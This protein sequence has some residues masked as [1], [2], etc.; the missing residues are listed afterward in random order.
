MRWDDFRRSSNVEDERGS[1]G[2]GFNMP[3]GAGGLGIGTILILGLI[4]WAL[5]IDPSVLI[6]GAQILQGGGGSPTQQSGAPP[7]TSPQDKET[8]DF[9]S[10]VLGD[11][12]DR[13]TEIFRASGRTYHPPKLVLFSGAIQGG[14]GQ[15]RSAMGPFYCPR[16]QQVYLDTS[17]F[18]DMQR[19]F[20]ACSD[21]K[22]CRFSE[23]YVIAH[24]VGHHVQD[25]LGI[26]PRVTQAQ[27]SA[28]SQADVNALQ[29]RVELQADC[30]AGVWANHAQRK[31]SFLDAG[32]VDQALQT[33]SAIGDDR[34]QRET[35]G[36]VV[37]DAF[38]HGTSA[39]RKRWFLNGFNSGDVNACNTLKADSL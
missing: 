37:P 3:G 34:L 36:Y 28:S 39:Q 11:T 31:H 21:D 38:T 15:A 20:G 22:A 8:M 6:N 25:E 18:R 4:G 5:G 27:Q 23:A 10:A 30:L 17:F 14:C 26:L 24:E 2:G 33:A 12:E 19:K 32:D 29:V 16:D 13:W 9:V 7:Q 35:Q 1:G